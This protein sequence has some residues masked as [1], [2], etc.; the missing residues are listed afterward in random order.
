MTFHNSVYSRGLSVMPKSTFKPVPYKSVPKGLTSLPLL[1]NI[2]GDIE[3]H[4]YNQSQAQE[5]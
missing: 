5:G 4:R 1:L 2:V 3:Y